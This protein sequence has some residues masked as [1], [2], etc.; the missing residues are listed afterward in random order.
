MSAAEV[1]SRMLELGENRPTIEVLEA[2]WG[3]P[4]LFLHSG[5]GIP[6]WEAALPL[7][8]EHF[9][10][11]APLLPGFGKST[12]LEFIDDKLD[13]V[14]HCFDVCEAL[15]LERPYLVGESLGG[16]LAAEMAALRPKEV[17]RLALAAPVGIW[18]DEAPVQD[19]FGMMSHELVPYL[20]H[21]PD[22]ES[23]RRMRGVSDLLS[24]KDDRTD[25]QVE[26]LLGLQRGLRTMAKFL[27]PIPDT[28]VEK[29]LH[30]IKAPTLVIWGAQDR[31]IAPS[32]GRIFADRIA[33]ARLEMIDGAGHAIAQEQPRQ[34]ADM[35][36]A[37]GR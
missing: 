14:L 23:A 37:F 15:G 34:Y 6:V 12:G 1:R 21:D 9:R 31:F 30:R 13:L 2:G 19:M 18:R 10:V 25:E 22:C 5:G 16:W 28:G 29:R 17:G 20:F 33:G 32:Y 4:L 36:I 8:A 7:L 11:V 26:F 35:L 3:E 24:N 27:F